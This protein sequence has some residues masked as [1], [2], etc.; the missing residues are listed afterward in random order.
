M[1]SG[2]TC[3]GDPEMTFRPRDVVMLDD[4]TLGYAMAPARGDDCLG[5][6]IATTLQVQ[7]YEVP[8]PMI[9]RRV[10]AGDDPDVISAEAWARLLEWC[11]GRGLQVLYHETTPVDRDRWIGVCPWSGLFMGH[12][13]VMS[14]SRVLFDP[15]VGVEAPP[16]MTTRTWGPEE[17][18]YGLSFEPVRKET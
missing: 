1:R 4:G 2:P 7:P 9:S 11:D 10:F 8:D 15:A 16:G 5:A 14:Y 13:L 12:C 3:A 17:V 6:A 18:A